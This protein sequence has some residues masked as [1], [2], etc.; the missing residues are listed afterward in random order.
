M[1]RKFIYELIQMKKIFNKY[2]MHD[3]LSDLINL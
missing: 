3:K 1:F 2:N